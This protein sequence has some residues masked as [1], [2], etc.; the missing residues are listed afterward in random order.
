MVYGSDGATTS[1]CT[2]HFDVFESLIFFLLRC[3]A[4][5]KPPIGLLDPRM[6][7]SLT[8]NLYASCFTRANIFLCA[9]DKI[10][11]R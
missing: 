7:F 10:F 9:Y 2:E 1:A 5:W 8:F 4:L 11:L 3:V 6:A